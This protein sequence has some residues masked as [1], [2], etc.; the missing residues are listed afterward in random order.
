VARTRAPVQSGQPNEVLELVVIDDD[1]KLPVKLV[2]A[3]QTLYRSFRAINPGPTST[4]F[5]SHLI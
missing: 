2:Q 4:I 5:S 3:P 1:S